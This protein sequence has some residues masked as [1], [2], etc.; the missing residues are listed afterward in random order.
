MLVMKYPWDGESRACCCKREVTAEPA[1]FR[2]SEE[3][4]FSSQ[5]CAQGTSAVSAGEEADT[6]AT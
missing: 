1:L 6:C 5:L 3:S 2:G 4:G